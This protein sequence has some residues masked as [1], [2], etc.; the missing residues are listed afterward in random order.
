MLNSMPQYRAEPIRI[1]NEWFDRVHN[2]M[3]KKRILIVPVIL[4]GARSDVKDDQDAETE[5]DVI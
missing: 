5:Y 4:N 3:D 1:L 2:I